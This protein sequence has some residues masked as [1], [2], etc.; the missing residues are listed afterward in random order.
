MRSQLGLAVGTLTSRW[1]GSSIVGDFSRLSKK[2]SG[3][4]PRR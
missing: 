1:I 3:P 4:S 2:S